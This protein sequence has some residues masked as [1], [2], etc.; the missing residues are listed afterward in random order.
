MLLYDWIASIRW[1]AKSSVIDHLLNR[2]KEVEAV[3]LP[4]GLEAETWEL[5]LD[6]DRFVLKIW[7][8]E[9]DP[10]VGFQY[11]LLDTLHRQGVAVSVPLGW[12]LDAANHKVLVTSFDGSP[13]QSPGVRTFVDLAALMLAL[14]KRPL[15]DFAPALHRRCDFI[16][17]YY[18][19]LREHPDIESVLTGLVGNAEMLQ[20]CM[21]HGD[22][23]LGNMVEQQGRYTIIDWTNAQ[24]GDPRYDAAW[25]AFL[26]AIYDGEEGYQAFLD[27]YA[28]ASG[29]SRAELEPFEA[30]ACL[31]WVLLNR[32]AD[33]PKT[34]G[35][36][37]RVNQAMNAN[38][39]VQGHRELFIAE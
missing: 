9:S 32:I 27:A 29:Y 3:R 34:E 21:I 11:T 18:P 13:V 30:M 20:T 25:A 35:T 1:T 2:V 19:R 37:R 31:R 14:H 22:V 4:A 38:A 36:I 8:K 12:G 15:D 16:A 7:N 10:D 6:D 24:L 28:A 26:A 33:I 5:R 17:Y 23:H 39:Y